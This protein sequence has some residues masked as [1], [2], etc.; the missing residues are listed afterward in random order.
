MKILLLICPRKRNSVEQI[1]TAMQK[2]RPLAEDGPSRHEKALLDSIEIG[3]QQGAENLLVVRLRFELLCPVYDGI[4]HFQ[5]GSGK[6]QARRKIG[7]KR[8]LFHA[9]ALCKCVP[10]K[11]DVMQNGPPVGTQKEKYAETT[12]S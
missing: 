5:I 10:V 3:D 9:V 1:I 7:D 2:S 6:S 4:G 8:L 11:E 12:A